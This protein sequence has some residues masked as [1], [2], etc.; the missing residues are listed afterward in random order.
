MTL[1]V[2][3]A[4]C[5]KRGIA[6]SGGMVMMRVMMTAIVALGIM[7]GIVGTVQAQSTGCKAELAKY[8]KDVKPGGGRIIQC[9]RKNDKSLSDTCRAYVNTASQYMACLDDAARLCPEAQPGAGS[10]I[11]CLRENES[12]LS[13]E[14]QSELQ[15]LRR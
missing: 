7:L 8:C 6:G 3:C 4:P 5:A 10:A 1:T 14:C 13:M 9:L 2:A 11:A 15:K 12:D